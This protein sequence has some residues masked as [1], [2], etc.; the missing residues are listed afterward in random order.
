MTLLA[1]KFHRGEARLFF[2]GKES[3]TGSE[4]GD[5][6]W[7]WKWKSK[8]NGRTRRVV[9]AGLA[10]TLREIERIDR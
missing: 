6:K 5:G 4:T 7:K 2:H 8:A 3:G 10:T 9:E 1:L